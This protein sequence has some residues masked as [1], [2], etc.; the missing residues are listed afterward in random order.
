MAGTGIG[1]SWKKN[2]GSKGRQIVNFN[3]GLVPSKS[4]QD[5]RH[6]LARSFGQQCTMDSNLASP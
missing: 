6:S 1:A 4:I 2:K 3:T 5:W